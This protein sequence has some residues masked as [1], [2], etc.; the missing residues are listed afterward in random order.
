M[1]YIK[2]TTI[3]RDTVMTIATQFIEDYRLRKMYAKIMAP[4]RPKYFL[5]PEIGVPL[6]YW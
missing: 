6:P 5:Y 3:D 4:E 1:Q 2:S